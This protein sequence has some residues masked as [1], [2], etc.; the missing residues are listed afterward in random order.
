MKILLAT[1]RSTG[2][3]L[4]TKIPLTKGLPYKIYMLRAIRVED[5]RAGDKFN[6]FA[7]FQVTF[8]GK[9]PNGNWC[10]YPVMACCFISVYDILPPQGYPIDVGLPILGEIMDPPSGQNIDRPLIHHYRTRMQGEWE[11]DKDYT[12]KWFLV[13]GYS[14]SALS[15]GGPKEVLD[16][17]LGGGTVWIDQYR[18]LTTVLNDEGYVLCKK[19]VEE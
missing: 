11:A 13:C 19:E 3:E 18:D 6:A 17:N 14:A 12:H 15:T 8:D 9:Y 16:V 1:H 7:G 4:V 10:N 5:I 2:S